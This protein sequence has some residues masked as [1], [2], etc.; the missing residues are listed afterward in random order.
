MRENAARANEAHRIKEEK[1]SWADEA[2][3]P[4]IWRADAFVSNGIFTMVTAHHTFKLITASITLL[5]LH[6]VWPNHPGSLLDFCL[7]L[8]LL[9]V[10][11]ALLPVQLYKAELYLLILEVE[12]DHHN[13]MKYF[14]ASLYFT[15][16]CWHFILHISSWTS[17]STSS[18]TTA[19]SS[20]ISIPSDSYFTT[21][22]HQNI[23]F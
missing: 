7:L 19:S 9:P 10:R 20:T 17:S 11:L 21:G 13:I 8:H 1:P 14:D 3:Q 2:H 6:Q 12:I 15:P 4:A 16:C 18:T 23:I 22:L 5:H